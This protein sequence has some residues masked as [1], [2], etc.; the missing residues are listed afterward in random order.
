MRPAGRW[1]RRKRLQEGVGEAAGHRT[2]PTVL[3]VRSV[4]GCQHLPDAQSQ[5]WAWAPRG[6][7]SVEENIAGQEGPRG[8]EKD[9]WK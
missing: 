6:R 5:K 3:P 1:G 8:R 2:W 4:S 7:G 9:G